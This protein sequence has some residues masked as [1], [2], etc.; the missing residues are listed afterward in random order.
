MVS[1]HPPKGLLDTHLTSI[2]FELNIAIMI[3]SVHESQLET[4]ASWLCANHC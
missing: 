2:D 4:T 3:I 1:L